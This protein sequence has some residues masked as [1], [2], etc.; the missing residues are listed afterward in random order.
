MTDKNY[1]LTQWRIM[2]TLKLIDRINEELSKD[3]V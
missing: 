3:V 1:W 2:N